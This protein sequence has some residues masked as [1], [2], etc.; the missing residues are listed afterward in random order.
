MVKCKLEKLQEKF[1]SP[2]EVPHGLFPRGTEK[3]HE[4]HKYI[5]VLQKRSK[6]VQLPI[7]SMRL[8]T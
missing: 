3:N 8:S 5:F 1:P 7:T 4:E 2:V 6:I